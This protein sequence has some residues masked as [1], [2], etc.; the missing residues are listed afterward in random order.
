[1][2]LGAEINWKN[3]RNPFY[4]FLLSVSDFGIKVAGDSA[5]LGGGIAGIIIVVITIALFF[6][7][8]VTFKSKH[9]F[10]KW[11]LYLY[12][13]LT[14]LL[15]PVLMP[16]FAG[17]LAHSLSSL[18]T[19]PSALN[20]VFSILYILVFAGS[21]VVYYISNGFT[22][23]SPVIL[24]S[25]LGMWDYK[26]Y[27]KIVFT[28]SAGIFFSIVLDFFPMWTSIFA[29]LV[30]CVVSAS[31]ILKL[32]DFPFFDVSVTKFFAIPIAFAT[33][34]YLM[35]IV[36]AAGI[37]LSAWIRFFVPFG[38]SI[39]ADIIIYKLVMKKYKNVKKKMMQSAIS[40]DST[41]RVERTESEKNEYFETFVFKSVDDAICYL[42]VGLAERCDLFLDFSFVRYLVMNYAERSIMMT[43]TQ[44]VSFFPSELQMLTQLLGNLSQ[45][46]D[47]SLIEQF[48]IYQVNKIHIT[49]QSSVSADAKSSISSIKNKSQ[50]N[51]ATVRCMWPS[52]QASQQRI[53]L[54]TLNFIRKESLETES[55]FVDL[56]EKFPN[57]STLYDEYAC[58]LI[59][60]M[61]NFSRALHS[62]N[63]AACVDRGKKSTKDY[64]YISMVNIYPKYLF[65]HI[66][67]TRGNFCQKASGLSSSSASSAAFSSSTT[68]STSSSSTIGDD[69]EVKNEELLSNFI[70]E[71]HMR[72]A[73]QNILK[74]SSLPSIRILKAFM[75]VALIVFV[76]VS[77]V[78]FIL[79]PYIA[80]TSLSN[81][82]ENSNYALASTSF[83]SITFGSAL[84][85]AKHET[86]G[87]TLFHMKD[88]VDKHTGLYDQLPEE[89]ILKGT[90]IWTH[91]ESIVCTNA[92]TD[93]F[94]SIVSGNSR[95]ETVNAYVNG[96]SYMSGF[97]NA[98]Q[99]TL[100]PMSLK[101][102]FA[103]VINN[104]KF[105]VGVSDVMD[106]QFYDEG[107]MISL[108]KTAVINGVNLPAYILH[109]TDLLSEDG[110]A[111]VKE[112]RIIL[113]VMSYGLSA[114]LLVIFGAFAAVLITKYFSDY[115]KIT[116]VLRSV[117]KESVEESRMPIM[118]GVPEKYVDAGGSINWHMTDNCRFILPV[119]IILLIA[120]SCIL[121]LFSTWMF[122]EL[123]LFQRVFTYYKASSQR[124][125]HI[126]HFLNTLI[127]LNI[128]QLD[129][130]K[131]LENVG[132]DI[133][134]V[135]SAHVLLMTSAT[136][137]DD[138]LDEIQLGTTC[139][140]SAE[141]SP[142]K[143]ITCSCLDKR[144][145][146]LLRQMQT[147][148]LAL[149][150]GGAYS[151]DSAE[152]SR[153]L[154]IL[155]LGLD[156]Q[157]I[158][159]NNL[160]I[161]KAQRVA[162]SMS[163]KSRLISAVSI[164]ISLIVF[165][166]LYFIMTHIQTSFDGF[167]QLIAVLPPKACVT[168]KILMDF[169]LGDEG[170]QSDEVMSFSQMII[171]ASQNIVLSLTPE[172]VIENANQS[173]K[174]ITG[175]G[176]DTAL[177]QNL[178]WLIPSVAGS[179]T[180]SGAMSISASQ[181]INEG[182][183]AM[184]NEIEEMRSNPEK[185][186]VTKNVFVNCETGA[187]IPASA[188]VIA[189]REDDKLI[190]F[191]VTIADRTQEIAEKEEVKE[192][193]KR[194]SKLLRGLLPQ[195]AYNILRK[196][197]E[198]TLFV[199]DQAIVIFVNINGFS[200]IVNV[201]QPSAVMD[202][203]RTIYEKFD[204][205]RRKYP[206]VERLK[207]NDELML[208]CAGLFNYK[209]DPEQQALQ[210]VMFSL[211]L[212]AEIPQ[213]NDAKNVNLGLSIGLNNGGP[214][215]GSVLDLK[216]PT[217]DI[218]GIIIGNAM[219]MVTECAE[220]VVQVSE[221]IANYLPHD[222]Y[223]I[224]PGI[225]LVAWY[226]KKKTPIFNVRLKQQNGQ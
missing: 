112:Q 54:E 122:S 17:I 129:L 209:D 49:R 39:I 48:F 108:L 161:K 102:A 40:A 150:M 218:I 193:K 68:S 202:L 194:S 72:I 11:Q 43:I 203:L 16:I 23:K 192:A 31:T 201:L 92:I 123:D 217:F 185:N 71:G 74:K 124:H 171:N 120:V 157:L 208:C 148:Q 70:K 181:T 83:S 158:E 99:L 6:I 5:L 33:V 85:I 53:S 3:G 94:Y 63:Q 222:K 107:T 32:F 130:E 97:D 169:I 55:A 180:S 159:F 156:D 168:N 22:V 88:S 67:D 7:S 196:Q 200:E 115:N 106:S 127:A 81:V 216:T 153:I 166:I 154:V 175:Y 28:A 184:Y 18:I 10:H 183:T 145:D 167:K 30:L 136:A 44:F 128:N 45:Q 1:M 126:L 103:A 189:M 125:S 179:E 9:S 105:G 117:K 98:N 163:T 224:T 113:Y 213:I 226:S 191:L 34:S 91:R 198:D 21:G 223:D 13:I 164:C 197:S 46:R 142:L 4:A 186:V 73:M 35:S 225:P 19:E 182:S 20:I 64:V 170:K 214:L 80:E 173:L 131:T 139:N 29:C 66:T 188:T 210:S 77:I 76:C 174:R 160:M 90:E 207:T 211:D 187:A 56:T 147:V 165:V 15:L 65:L 41:D 2:W 78:I 138:A 95:S 144:I 121:I 93:V 60:A 36:V 220:N 155:D 199:S 219:K 114:L 37:N 26:L 86:D 205:I 104:V 61:G 149:Q 42:R 116:K 51:I 133:T 87:T 178:T 38:V 132:N 58:F 111:S 134:T 215:C 84:M 82:T 59:E 146:Y 57:N 25:Q 109:V 79:I 221:G 152:F 50:K 24:Y 12:R 140:D 69:F 206:A 176:N 137:Y 190:G 110:F 141:D 14:T 100:V 62:K 177:R 143:L 195:E 27:P 47:L 151:L 172:L 118:N 212:L 89:G 119:T 135:Q 52:I 204:D 8:K 101:A 96:T 75:Y 162:D